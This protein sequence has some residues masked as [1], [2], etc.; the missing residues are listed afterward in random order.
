MLLRLTVA[1]LRC[2]A[3]IDHQSKHMQSDRNLKKYD[4][5][6]GAHFDVTPVPGCDLWKGAILG[7]A[8]SVQSMKRTESKSAFLIKYVLFRSCRFI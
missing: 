1:A 7:V 2:C 6:E 8:K 5:S 4:R 3:R